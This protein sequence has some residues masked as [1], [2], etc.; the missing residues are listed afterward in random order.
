MSFLVPARRPGREWLDD[1]SLPSDAMV[2]NL[3]DIARVDASWGGSR[4]LARWLL[5][6]MAGRGERRA[7]VLDVGAGSAQATRRLRRALASRGVSADV[8]ALDLQ[9]R[10]LAA[11]LRSN[12]REPLPGVAA[13]AFRLPLADAS[14]DWAVSTL[15]L[16][17]FSPGELAALLAEIR[18]VSRRGFALLDLRRHRLLLAFVAVAGRIAFT[19]RVSLHDGIASVRQAYTP[20]ELR[21]VLRRA[22]PA[23]KVE[24]LFPFRVLVSSSE[25]STLN[26]TLRSS[27]SLRSTSSRP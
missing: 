27:A 15:L 11:G 6:R 13:D 24:R 4:I 22:A 3:A 9:W 18:R 25:P 20:E 21:E 8:F 1:P 14:V 12:G 10:H 5:E 17:H 19:T 16:H 23:A 2:R 26:A 7:S